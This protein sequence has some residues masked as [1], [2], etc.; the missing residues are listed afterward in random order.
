LTDCACM[1]YWIQS[2]IFKPRT[3]EDLQKVVALMLDYVITCGIVLFLFFTLAF[4]ARYTPVGNDAFFDRQSTRA[5]RGFWSVVII[6]VHIPQAYQNTIQDLAGSFAYIGVTFFF[7]AS[8]YGL[9][10]SLGSKPDSIHTFWRNRLPRLII[11]NW[12]ANLFFSLLFLVT[13]GEAFHLLSLLHINRWLLWLLLCYAAFWIVHRPECQKCSPHL[14]VCLLVTSISLAGYFLERT[15]II[16][17]STWWTEVMGFV[18]GTL[19]YANYGKIKVC[20]QRHWWL[21]TVVSCLLSLTLG[22]LYLQSKTI[23]FWGDYVLKILLGLAI[24]CFILSL[25]SRFRIGNRISAF[26]GDISFEVYLIHSPVF[27]LIGMIAP[28]LSSGWFILAAISLTV[29]L[30][31]MIH[32][33]CQLAFQKMHGKQSR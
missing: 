5:M 12:T 7:M 17:G 29:C 32:H 22:L 33:I 20:F 19:L 9:S 23:V 6:L 2:L 8:A 15:G 18:W 30:A 11:P 1:I 3:V 31:A 24:L 4:K 25:N 14:I 21:S 16:Q 10:A 26:L 28:G 13:Y 27:R